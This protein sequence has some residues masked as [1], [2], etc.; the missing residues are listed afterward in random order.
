MSNSRRKS[1][2]TSNLILKFYYLK[3]LNRFLY[4]TMYD[5]IK[6]TY[7]T[8][9]IMMKGHQLSAYSRY[10]KQNLIFI[11]CNHELR[12]THVSPLSLGLFA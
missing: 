4:F 7:V 1:F 2:K 8:K 3:T 11:N 10:I 6:Y 12:L 5:E 9:W